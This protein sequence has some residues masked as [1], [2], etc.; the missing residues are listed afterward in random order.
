M[1][2]RVPFESFA[3]TAKKTLGIGDAY[4]IAHDQHVI[5]SAAVADKPCIVLSE[6]NL[7]LSEA[8]AAL[9][10]SG[11]E[12]KDGQW[13]WGGEDLPVMAGD[14]YVAAVSYVSGED[15][16]GIWVD[17]YPE[18]PSQMEV[19]KALHHEFR[20]TGEMREV[21]FEEFVRLAKPSVVVLSPDVLTRF[22]LAKRGC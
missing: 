11:I 17:V 1:I 18:A 2:L 20:S 15:K 9:K 10:K 16:P 21:S 8:K 22:L 3:E 19:L 5:A 7:T 6:T 14:S 4:I 12:A 13:A